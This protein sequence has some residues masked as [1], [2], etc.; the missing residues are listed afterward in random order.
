[1]GVRGRPRSE[2]ADTAIAA[3]VRDLLAT[4]GY[5]RLTMDHV[6]YTA[7]VS[8]ATIYRRW[9][10][11]AEMVAECVSGLSYDMIRFPDTGDTRGDLV[12]YLRSMVEAIFD[13]RGAMVTNLLAEFLHHPELAAAFRERIPVRYDAQYR[14]MIDRCVA[15]GDVRSDVE[16]DLV[17][18][19][20]IGAVYHR[21]LLMGQPVDDTAVEAIVDLFLEGARA[22]P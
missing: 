9:H 21:V 6:A 19:L 1:M 2:Q 11:K 7:G 17:G 20:L 5:A 18:N 12:D 22:R 4:S 8:K 15:R 14:A 3:A 10:N 13:P 16:P